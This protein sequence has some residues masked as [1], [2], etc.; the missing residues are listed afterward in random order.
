MYLTNALIHSNILHVEHK[1]IRRAGWGQM[2]ASVILGS[3]DLVGSCKTY[4]ASSCC[5]VPHS[6]PEHWSLAGQEREHSC[7]WEFR[8][9]FKVSPTAQGHQESAKLKRTEGCQ[10]HWSS[11]C[12]KMKF[13]DLWSNHSSEIFSVWI[14][15]SVDIHSRTI[16][17]DR[18][19]WERLYVVNVVKKIDWDTKIGALGP[20]KTMWAVEMQLLL[21]QA[22]CTV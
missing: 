14:A 7:C 19:E 11:C 2:K 8:H 12:C 21:S 6:E 15:G 5:Q 13:F 4:A 9:L 3:V 1:S 17:F 22:M 10:N 20:A 16:C 18:K